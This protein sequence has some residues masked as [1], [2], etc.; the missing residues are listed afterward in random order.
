MKKNMLKKPFNVMVTSALVATTLLTP[1]VSMIPSVKA[2]ELEQVKQPKVDE[3]QNNE[4]TVPSPEQTEENSQTT[5]EGIEE[6]ETNEEPAIP[7]VQPAVDEEAPTPIEEVKNIEQEEKIDVKEEKAVVTIPDDN[8]RAVIKEKL[9]VQNDNEI[10]EER[11]NTMTGTLNANEKNIRNI[12]GLEHAIKINFI[13]LGGNNVTDLSPLRNLTQLTKLWLGNN[14][15]NSLTPL[16]NLQNLQELFITDNGINDLGPLRNLTKLENLRAGN[17]SIRDLGPLVNL[18]NLKELRLENNQITNVNP[19]R[20]LT[21]LHTLFLTSNAIT[22]VL[23]LQDLTNLTKLHLSQNKTL[24]NLSPLQGLVKLTELLITNISVSDLTPLN[25][26]H[27]LEKLHAQTNQITNIQPLENLQNLTELRLENNRITDANPLKNLQKLNSVSLNSNWLTQL[28]TELEGK[29]GISRNFMDGKTEQFA[30]AFAESTIKIKQGETKNIAVNWT[31]NGT[32]NAAPTHIPQTPTVRPDN[33]NADA[34][35]TL[36]NLQVTGKEV[37]TTVVTYEPVPGLQKTVTVD[38][39]A[40]DI[41]LEAPEVDDFYEKDRYV[42]G[43]VK[44]GTKKIQLH[45]EAGNLVKTGTVNDDNTFV[46]YVYD[47]NYPVGTNLQ[48][49]PLDASNKPGKTTPFTVQQKTVA[50]VDAPDVNEYYEREGYVTGTV[51]PGTKKIQLHKEG[52]LVK[53]GAIETDGTFKIYAGD[54]KYPAGTNLEAVPFGENDVR[55]QATPFTVKAIDDVGAPTVNDYH[56]KESY[57]TG[58][59]APGT[60]KIQLHKEGVLVK[61]GAIETDGTFKIYA[62]DQKYP[63]GTELDIVPLNQA[64]RPGIKKTIT[65]ISQ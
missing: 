13:N 3:N 48:A 15:I 37:G 2:E 47:K 29:G 23:Q 62:G 61:T 34:T 24:T 32:A 39:E 20:N 31:L 30:Y 53:T 22:D 8:L 25:S 65:V 51:K 46:I 19:L 45:D 35:G 50:P 59:V 10:T 63:V 43:T 44:D 28:P 42:T 5:P 11:M 12:T 16:E 60:K 36:T 56:E 49:V 33:G 41:E 55:G 21:N 14:P 52:V 58:N 7:S 4:E 27:S 26:L 9:N 38:V 40:A 54:Q 18:Q 17:N 64:D 57:I 1:T 6:K